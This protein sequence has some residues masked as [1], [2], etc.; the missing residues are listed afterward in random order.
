MGDFLLSVILRFSGLSAR[1]HVDLLATRMIQR[2]RRFQCEKCLEVTD[3]AGRESLGCTK[4]A[5]SRFP[6]AGKYQ[7]TLCPGNYYD[8]GAAFAFE[9]YNLFRQGHLPCKGT[10]ADQPAQLMEAF[11]VISDLEHQEEKE[12]QALLKRNNRGK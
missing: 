1:D 7:L 9:L 2:N 11:A 12:K 4:P 3:E 5:L 10:V 6:L 8:E